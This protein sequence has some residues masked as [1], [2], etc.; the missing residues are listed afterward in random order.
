MQVREALA[1]RRTAKS[2]AGFRRAQRRMQQLV[3][4]AL[5]V[6]VGSFFVAAAPTTEAAQLAADLFYKGRCGSTLIHYFRVSVP[7]P[8]LAPPLSVG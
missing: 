4:N 8:A 2:T 6:A 1:V 7:S 3:L 5:R